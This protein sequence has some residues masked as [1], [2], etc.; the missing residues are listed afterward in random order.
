MINKR[1]D[2]KEAHGNEEAGAN[3][4]KKELRK[5]KERW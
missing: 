3:E 4:A 2:M 5:A 1:R